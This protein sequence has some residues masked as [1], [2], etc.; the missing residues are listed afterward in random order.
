MEDE[1]VTERI[2]S[3][4]C[5]EVLLIRCIHIYDDTVMSFC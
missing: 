3:F 2:D 1:L 5:F 4:L